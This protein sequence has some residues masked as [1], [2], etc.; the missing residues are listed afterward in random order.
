MNAAL[1]FIATIDL[2]SI[3]P[4]KGHPPISG[5]VDALDRGTQKVMR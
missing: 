1:S 2:R 5:S 3:P 4:R